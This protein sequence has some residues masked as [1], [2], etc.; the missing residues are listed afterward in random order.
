MP[1]DWIMRATSMHVN[2]SDSLVQYTRLCMDLRYLQW[3][4]S[5]LN[6]TK[7]PWSGGKFHWLD[8]TRYFAESDAAW[9]EGFYDLVVCFP[10]IALQNNERFECKFSEWDVW[11]PNPSAQFKNDKPGES[12]PN[13]HWARLLASQQPME[14]KRTLTD[15]SQSRPTIATPELTSLL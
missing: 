10:G 2:F 8:F 5:E 14:R 7:W 3:R 11:K 9:L 13:Y 15:I 1:I 12:A 6:W 4:Y